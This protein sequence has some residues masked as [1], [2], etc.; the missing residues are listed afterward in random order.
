MRKATS[1][2]TTRR[3]IENAIRRNHPVT[4]SYTSLNG[5]DIVRTIEPYALDESKAGDTLVKSMDREQGDYR[6]F[7]LDRISAYTVHRTSFKIK[8]PT[9]GKEVYLSMDDGEPTTETVL[10]ITYTSSK[11][12][13]RT[14][15]QYGTELTVFQGTEIVAT[16]NVTGTDVWELIHMN[17]KK[18]P[19]YKTVDGVIIRAGLR[20]LDYDRKIG[21]VDH[22]QFTRGGS[23]DPGGEYFDGWF[24]V[25]RDDGSTGLFNGERLTTRF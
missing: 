20:V 9:N 18:V 22:E 17:L 1:P 15:V 25:V 7:R 6:S 19:E 2:E 13:G 12:D 3:M 21:T 14:A 10:P 11:I 5:R 16:H 24:Q 8:N 23:C 4:I